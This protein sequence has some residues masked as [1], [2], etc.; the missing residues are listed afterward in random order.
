MTLKEAE[1]LGLR[2]ERRVEYYAIGPTGMVYCL[3][4]DWVMEVSYKWKKKPKKRKA[5]K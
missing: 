2:I 5:T 3:Y 4:P 1:K